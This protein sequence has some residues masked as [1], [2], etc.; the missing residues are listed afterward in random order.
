MS[1]QTGRRRRNSK[2]NSSVSLNNKLKK[3]RRFAL[4]G[5]VVFGVT[6]FAVS[7]FASTTTSEANGA[8]CQLNPSNPVCVVPE[9]SALEGTAALAVIAAMLLMMWERR[10][11]A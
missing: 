3:R 6:A 11:Q 2:H 7:I 8:L 10:R 4:L 9:I 1:N 5:S